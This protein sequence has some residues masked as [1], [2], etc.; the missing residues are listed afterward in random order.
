MSCPFARHAPLFLLG[1]SLALAGCTPSPE[2]AD[3]P[4]SSRYEDLVGLFHDWRSFQVPNMSDEV[5]DYTASAM[6]TQHAELA[7]YRRR[8]A[9][10][11]PRGWPVAQQVDYHLVRAE[12]NGL[13]FD[14]RV[15]RP[16]ARD[17]A[18]YTVIHAAQSDVPA[19]EGPSIH[20][21]IEIWTYEFPVTGTR[22]AQLRA[23]L[24]AVPAILE[25]ARRNLVGDTRDLW[26]ASVRST[27]DQSA[28]LAALAERLA[29]VQPDLVA[30]VQAAH[31]A[32]GDFVAW[33]E[34]EAPKKK[35]P[36]GVGVEHYD[37]YL[38]NVHLL[39][40]TWQD[41]LMLVRRELARSH[42]VLKLEEHRNRALPPLE[43]VASEE[44][45]T[46]RFNEAVGEYI[47]FLGDRDVLSVAPYMD[48]ALRARIG[49]FRPSDGPREFFT[50]VD[51]R[52]PVIMRTHGFH[53]IDLA[54]MAEAP[55][56]S[57]IR[58]VPG[59][60]NLWDGRAEGLAT[61]MEE[62]MMHAGLFDSRPRAR[63]LI[64]VLLAQRAARAMGDLMMHANRWT[65]DE[66]ARFASSWTPRG[67]LRTD[68]E[69]VW[70]E[71]QLYL[72]QP[73][74]GT[75]YIVGKIEIEKLMADVAHQRGEQFTLK[76]FMDDFQASG[77]VPVSLIRWEMTGL[78][79]EIAELQKAR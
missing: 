29:S 43:P 55:H 14:H 67:W 44:E 20:G 65:L 40:Y 60:Y 46:R 52:D 78:A 72:Q 37:W 28:T 24:R 21:G 36:S 42:A 9:A 10:I 73:T 66:A 31:R 41:Q 74:Y 48:G 57:A 3:A 4:S 53:W 39:P 23:K 12:M 8:L 49:R 50:E 6:A 63:E 45:H 32:V 38:R 34:A 61:G 26:M 59:L 33:L 7:K 70:G 76:D 2:L 71:Q 17:P 77:V 22:L 62:M 18:F 58:R 19:H 25:Q 35:G 30:D 11:D 54:R 16:W 27:R 64:Y 68:G 1:C 13:D 56:Q 79:D 75:S 15:R 47:A 5:P 51:Y 69:T